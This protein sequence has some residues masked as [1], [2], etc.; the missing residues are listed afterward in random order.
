MPPSDF[1][2]LGRSTRV[3]VAAATRSLRKKHPAATI[4]RHFSPD[5]ESDDGCCASLPPK[6]NKATQIISALVAR[7]VRLASPAVTNRVHRP[8]GVPNQNGSQDPAPIEA[9]QT[10]HSARRIPVRVEL[11]DEV[12]QAKREHSR[13][14]VVPIQPNNFSVRRQ[15]LERLKRH[16]IRPRVQQPTNVSVVKTVNRRM[17]IGFEI[18]MPVVMSVHCTPS[19]GAPLKLATPQKSP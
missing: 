13:N 3:P 1:G 4:A 9:K 6:T 15:V 10:V 7:I 11:T 8:G 17:K 12:E 18:G 19:D 16:L 2:R 14:E 5:L